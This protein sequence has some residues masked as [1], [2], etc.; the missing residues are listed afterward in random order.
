MTDKRSAEIDRLT[1]EHI[2]S[3]MKVPAAMVSTTTDLYK[4]VY[5]EMSAKVPDDFDPD[6]S[7]P[8][9]TGQKTDNAGESKKRI[10]SSAFGGNLGNVTIN[11]S[12]WEPDEQKTAPTKPVNRTVRSDK[13]SGTFSIRGNAVDRKLHWLDLPTDSD[14]DKYSSINDVCKCLVG[15]YKKRYQQVSQQIDELK[16]IVDDIDKYSNYTD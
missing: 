1:R 2:A 9:I 8:T 15:V 10:K 7:A 5:D 3:E 11:D 13:S 14:L 12:I 6:K 16:S 4:K